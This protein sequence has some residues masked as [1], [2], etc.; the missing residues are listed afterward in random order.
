[1]AR[2]ESTG[3]LPSLTRGQ[4]GD[5]ERTRGTASRSSRLCAGSPACCCHFTVI[6]AEHRSS[7]GGHIPTSRWPRM[8]L[9]MLWLPKTSPVRTP[10]CPRPWA[11][12]RL[13]SLPGLRRL[14]RRQTRDRRETATRGKQATC[15]L[16]RRT[17]QR[18]WTSL[19]FVSLKCPKLYPPPEHKLQ[20]DNRIHN[21]KQQGTVI[22][23]R[24]KMQ[25]VICMLPPKWNKA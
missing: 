19:G 13:N 15:G 3:V 21:Y 1:M 2:T 8:P 20:D 10:C 14:Q 6:V 18:N 7:C 5:A 23:E 25:T 24:N 9:V 16:R 11:A 4:R 12:L 17:A 22:P